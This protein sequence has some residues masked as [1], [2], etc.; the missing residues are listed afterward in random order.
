MQVKIK[1]L[2]YRKK[3]ADQ[4]FVWHTLYRRIAFLLVSHENKNHPSAVATD[5]A[6]RA[7]MRARVYGCN[8]TKS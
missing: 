8:Q 6:A 4:V 1:R 5:V 7:T 2:R 3:I